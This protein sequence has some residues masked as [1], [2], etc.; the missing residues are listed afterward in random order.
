[1]HGRTARQMYG[2]RA[3]W[4]RIAELKRA[5]AIPVIGNGDVETADDAVE[6]FRQ[7]GCDA[8]M[9]GR[10]TM[11]NPWIFRQIADR[12]AGRPPREAT[13]AERRDL[14]LAHFSAIE[15]TAFDPREALHKLRT[16]TGWYT[17]GLPNGR[18]LRVRISSL[19]TP[20]D[21]RGAVT[22]F[23]GDLRDGASL[24]ATA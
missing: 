17:H 20:A 16:M 24:A 21:F 3:D 23:F 10:A 1:M 19:E 8:V 11:K 4:S 15:R 18:A 5:L 7:T 9:C 13:L 12:L 14:M 6:M 2:G 22:E